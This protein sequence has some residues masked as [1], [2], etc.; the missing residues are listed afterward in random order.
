MIPLK[1]DQLIPYS[2]S[3]WTLRELYSLGAIIYLYN[4]FIHAKSL[5]IDEFA[6]IIGSSNFDIRSNSLNL[7]SDMFIYS[8]EEI[9]EYKKIF[10]KDIKDSLEYSIQLEESLYK[11]LKFGKRFFRLLSSI[12]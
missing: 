11:Y 8:K 2:V 6:L 10:N 1:Y 5:I 4:G 12:L 9:E 3:L 7:E